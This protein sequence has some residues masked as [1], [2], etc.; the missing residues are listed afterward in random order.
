MGE[1]PPVSVRRAE[2]GKT[3]GQ[4]PLLGLPLEGAGKA[5]AIR[6]RIG[7]VGLKRALR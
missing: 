1:H 7:E 3:C 2:V 5:R 6:L 4:E